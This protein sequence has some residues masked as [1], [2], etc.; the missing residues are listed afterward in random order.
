[1]ANSEMIILLPVGSVEEHG[2]LPLDTDTLIARAF[3]ELVKSKTDAVVEEPIINGF[4][5]TTSSLAQTKSPGFEKVFQDVTARVEKLIEQ[6]V[7]YIVMVNIHGENGSVLTALVQDTYLRKNFPIFYFNPY[8]ALAGEIDQV[9][10]GDNDNSFKECSLLLASL[11]IL[12][13]ETI[14]GPS[15]DEDLSRDP[16]VE[17][18]RHVGVVGFS[19]K[20]SSQHVAWRAKADK[21]AG[22]KYLDESAEHFVLSINDFRKYVEQ[23]IEKK[24]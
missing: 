4:C 1:M 20:T 3:C 5:P 6:G 7:R 17:R 10:F 16:L 14:S 23:E 24:K 9:C 15:V 19:Y 22:R 2:V 12:G 8:L 21:Q 18:L 13:L 11:E